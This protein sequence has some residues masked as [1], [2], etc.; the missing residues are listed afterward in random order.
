MRIKLQ[1][2][3][4]IGLFAFW[5]FVRLLPMV[6]YPGLYGFDVWTHL[7]YTYGIFF[8][9]QIPPVHIP[10][11]P[12]YAHPALHITALL[13]ST[14][15]GISIYDSFFLLAT[16]LPIISFISSYVFLRTILPKIWLVQLALLILALNPDFL[17]QTNS[18]IP[19]ALALVFLFLSLTIIINTL[20]TPKLL[21]RMIIPL[22]A[23]ILAL[24][25]THHLATL[26]FTFACT[27]I[28]LGVVILRKRDEIMIGIPLIIIPAIICLTLLL[29]FD[30]FVMGLIQK[31]SIQLLYLVIF[32][33]FSV[34][35]LG[36]L[37][38]K[39]LPV[40][41]LISKKIKYKEVLVGFIIV[42][43]LFGIWLFYPL[44]RSGLWLFIK[45]LPLAILLG[46]SG[47]FTFI[48]FAMKN[49]FRQL[50]ISLLIW[51]A[52]LSMAFLSFTLLAFLDPS[53]WVILTAEV[54]L[55]HR[56]FTYM[57]IVT[58]PLA[59]LAIW[60]FLRK[61]VLTSVS[62][63]SQI[64]KLVSV[65]VILIIGIASSAGAWNVYNPV[66]G[67]HQTWF[68]LSEI[69]GANWLIYQRGEQSI[70][71]TDGRLQNLFPGFGPLIP[72]NH[73]VVIIEPELAIFKTINNSK[74]FIFISDILERR[75][76]LNF[77]TP[78]FQ[79]LL[80]PRL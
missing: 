27:A 24:Y 30:P 44:P 23:V 22:I 17:A 11:Y 2:V 66:D 10:N 80:R 42:I 25:L 40:L 48:L 32:A 46:L 37:G 54:A 51:L 12:Y 41:E 71:A 70:T 74:T 15:L 4:L 18:V 43:I 56:L 29:F 28:F 75:F 16:I 31:A 47:S 6:F 60:Y 65:G 5:I 1:S 53:S 3:T 55:A 63:K 38:P 58:A 39:L 64:R 13:L 73:D 20:R 33:I 7:G 49:S 26:I 77:A 34:V 78:P 36:I 69:Q 21:K 76:M 9:N 72:T 57:V 59:S 8:T 14:S 62:Q 79:V 35:I 61:Q 68:S 67:W 45:F 50:G 19:E 52:I